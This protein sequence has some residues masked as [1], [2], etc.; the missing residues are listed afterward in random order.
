MFS[1]RVALL[2]LC[3]ALLPASALSDA[4]KAGDKAAIRRLIK[5][6]AAINA[7]DPDGSTPLL[8]ATESDDTETA[9]LLL[10]ARAN[11]NAAN[12]NGITPLFLA[13]MNRNAELTTGKLLAAIEALMPNPAEGNPPPFLE[14]KGAEPVPYPAR[15]DPAAH[16]RSAA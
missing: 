6:R 8:W 11:A 1:K 13:A 5:D 3:A 14:G 7:T 12:R 9:L 2:G 16:A 4:I 10:N 15:P